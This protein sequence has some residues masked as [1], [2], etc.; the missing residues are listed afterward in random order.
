M[1]GDAPLVVGTV[2]I[3]ILSTIGA[4]VVGLASYVGLLALHHQL[5]KV[6]AAD[7]LMMVEM[8][9]QRLEEMGK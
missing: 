5:E 6:E 1:N 8:E 4:V 2:V 7:H 3:F 9:R